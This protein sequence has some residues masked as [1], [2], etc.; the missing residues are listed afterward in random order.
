MSAHDELA[1]S[2]RAAAERL[3]EQRSVRDLDETLSQ[4][5]S[6]AVNL[7]PSADAGGISM[8]ED[9]VVTSR[10]PTDP[11]VTELDRLQSELHEGP[12][13]SA[14]EDPAEDGVILADDLAAE[15]ATRW[16]RFSPAAVASGYRSVLS[17]QLQAREGGRAALNLYAAGARAFD[18]DARQTAALFALQATMLLYGSE[19]VRG[20]NRAVESRDVIGQAK[21]ILIERH[22]I[23]DTKAFQ[24]LVSASQD[25][26]IKLVEVARWLVSDTIAGRTG[27]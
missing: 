5:V 4:I 18:Q 8:V 17:T 26:N 6:A 19:A 27:L 20:L 10:N 24:M 9:G 12:C 1:A 14:L 7:V 16:P 21:G 23:D 11:G 13:I 22:G 15:D 3:L 2:L 25:T